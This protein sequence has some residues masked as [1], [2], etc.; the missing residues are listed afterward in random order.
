MQVGGTVTL[1]RLRGVILCGVLAVLLAGCVEVT[2]RVIVIPDSTL[3]VVLA[4]LHLADAR[5]RLPDQAIGLRDSVLV[6]HGLN[7]TVFQE[8]IDSFG[9]HPEELTKM[10]KPVLDQLNA[11]RSPTSN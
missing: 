4:D 3:I 10:Y 9:A 5:A 2:E 6:F 8:A 11:T 1:P 7:E